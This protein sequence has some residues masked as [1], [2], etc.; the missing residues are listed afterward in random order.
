MQ[1]KRRTCL[2]CNKPFDSYGPGNRICK[3]CSQI[4]ARLPRFSEA[5]MQVQRGAKRHN[6]EL[7]NDHPADEFSGGGSE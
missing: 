1:T 7:I 6:G 2:K 4:N 5:Q 3:R